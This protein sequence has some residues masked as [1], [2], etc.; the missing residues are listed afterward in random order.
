MPQESTD[1]L[2]SGLRELLVVAQSDCRRDRAR[3]CGIAAGAGGASR[4]LCRDRLRHRPQQ[5][6]THQQWRV[7]DA[8]AARTSA[9][10]RRARRGDFH[11]T[12]GFFRNR[13]SECACDLRADAAVAPPRAGPHLYRAHG[14]GYRA[15]FETRPVDRSGIHHLSRHDAGCAQAH[16][17]K[18][19]AEGGRDFFLAYSPERED[20]GNP[21]YETST[22][23]RVVGGDDPLDRRSRGGT[24]RPDREQ[25]RAGG[26]LRHRRSGEADGEHLPRGEHRA[27][28][29]TEADLRPHGHQCVGCDRC[30]ENQ[31]LRLHAVLSGA[32]PRRALHSHR[33]VLPD[34]ES[35]RIQ[36]ADALHRACW[37]GQCGGTAPRHRRAGR[38]AQ[39][40]AAEEPLRRENP[41]A[42]HGLQ[43]ECR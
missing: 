10:P 22:I 15:A 35:A 40:Q 6:G 21:D 2:A 20:P 30:R 23:P 1:A 43:E 19:R 7:A 32:G 24:L 34:V 14:R 3:L 42:R 16:P 18:E 5:G 41:A 8:H 28:Q 13:E 36:C 37:R 12:V 29:R 11:A 27:R 25:G 4:G 17:R 33:S 31:A 9:W 39:R 38:S 26:K